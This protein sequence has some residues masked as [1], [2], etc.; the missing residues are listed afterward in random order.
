VQSFEEAV[1]MNNNVPQ[2]LSS[3]LFTSDMRKVFRW[4]G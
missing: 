4:M 2:G 1:A 3:S